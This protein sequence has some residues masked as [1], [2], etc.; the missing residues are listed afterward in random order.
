MFIE[1]RPLIE[2]FEFHT[3]PELNSGC[4]LWSG[5]ADTKGYGQIRIGGV[6]GKTRHTHR[7]AWELYRGPIPGDLHICH[8]CDTP[9]CVNS[10]HLFLGDHRA[11]MADRDRKGRC[12]ARGGKGSANG[13]AKLTEAQVTE[14]R[15]KYARGGISLVKLSKPYGICPQTAH[16]IVLRR[17]WSHAA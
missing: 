3:E 12:R 14:M 6:T 16:S 10:D 17:T 1:K 11:N 8:R 2:R 7:V 15:A 5:A 4:I 9:T 13:T